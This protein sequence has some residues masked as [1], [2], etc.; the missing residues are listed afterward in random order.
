RLAQYQ[1]NLSE[2]ETIYLNK[3]PYTILKNMVDVIKQKWELWEPQ[4]YKLT[5]RNITTAKD[6]V[7]CISNDSSNMRLRELIE[8]AKKTDSIAITKCLT[9]CKS[10]LKERQQA[11]QDVSKG[12]MVDLDEETVTLLSERIAKCPDWRLIAD[13]LGFNNL[14]CL[15]LNSPKQML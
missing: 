2:I 1:N 8:I 14:A 15:K 3:L 6:F 10:Y 13:G 4:A 12:Y 11:D 7:A 5:G 9:E